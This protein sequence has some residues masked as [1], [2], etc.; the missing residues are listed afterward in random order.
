M[1]FEITTYLKQSWAQKICFDIWLL[2]YIIGKK[3][4][5]IL[6]DELA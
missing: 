6:S 4:V 1:E 2:K 5:K 3:Y